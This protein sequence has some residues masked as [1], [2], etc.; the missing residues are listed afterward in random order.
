MVEVTHV[1]HMELSHPS[2]ETRRGLGGLY[3]K[4]AGRRRGGGMRCIL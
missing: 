2:A 4:K 3:S 1:R